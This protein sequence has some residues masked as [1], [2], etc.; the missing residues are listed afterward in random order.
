MP[1]PLFLLISNLNFDSRS[2]P[3][4]QRG[5]S[6]NEWKNK[7]EK[8]QRKIFK[9]IINNESKIILHALWPDG[10]DDDADENKLNQKM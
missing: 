8:F 2:E 6:E 3:A 10:D 1:S 9:L 4:A 7:N 5:Q